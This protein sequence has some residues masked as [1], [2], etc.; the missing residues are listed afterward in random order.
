MD[1]QLPVLPEPDHAN[2]PSSVAVTRRR[3]LIRAA[4]LCGAAVVSYC[5]VAAAA[6]L[7]D[8]AARMAQAYPD[9]L[10]KYMTPHER[11]L[12]IDHPTRADYDYRTP[13]TGVVYCPAEYE[14][15]EGL[16]IAWESYTSILTEMTVE[17]TTGDPDAVVYVVVDNSSEQTSAYGTL[18][19]AGADMTQVQFIVCTTD[20]VWIRDYGPRFIFDDGI[21]AIVDHTYNRPR[22]NDNQFPGFLGALWG[23]TV[24]D[25]PLEHGGG[26]FHLF[27]NGDAFMSDLILTEN[28]GLTEQQVK[29]LYDEYQNVDLTI[30]P[31]F[32]TTFDSTQHIDMWMLPVGDD[33]VI[34][35]QYSA[36]TGQPY[37]ITENAVAD[38]TARGY[39]VY[40][41]PGWNSGGTHYTY[42]NAVILND[43]VFISKFN[44]SQDATAL[45]VF[46]AA[47]PGYTIHQ[48]D[49][50]GIIGA[51]GALHCIVMH[52]PAYTTPNP[53]VKLSAPNGGE[54]WA[55]NQ[56]YEII[57]TARD[58]VGVTAVDI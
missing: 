46:Q 26:N 52:I 21:R 48:I 2:R 31:G 55:P 50:S 35:G 43:Q 14:L 27:S 10:P 24:Y 34:I 51:A 53:V 47:M 8:A 29:D 12:P 16:F 40:R 7:P 22:P 44:T 5:T 41:T 36:S 49:S 54:F 4:S 25:I 6:P 58:D 33:K 20:T 19:A 13:P 3:R 15:N 39:T 1:R 45:A 32:P 9:G 28:P 30:Y 37:T 42:T 56:P 17:I 23:E 38:L 11:L 18:S 57:W